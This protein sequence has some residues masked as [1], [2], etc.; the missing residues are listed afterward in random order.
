MIRTDARVSQILLEDADTVCGVELEGGEKIYA[1]VVLS[2]ATPKVTF[3]DLLPDGANLGHEFKQSIKGIDYSSVCHLS[4]LTIL[5][6][7]LQ[8]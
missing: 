3:L 8:R 2:N 5:L 7:R 6:R 4:F 1:P